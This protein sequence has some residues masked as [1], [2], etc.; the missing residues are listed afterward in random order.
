MHHVNACVPRPQDNA[1]RLKLIG[2]IVMHQQVPA[3]ILDVYRSEDAVLAEI[4]RCAMRWRTRLIIAVGKYLQP[5]GQIDPIWGHLNSGF[6]RG[7][8]SLATLN[9]PKIQPIHGAAPFRFGLAS[10]LARCLTKSCSFRCA[11]ASHLPP[12]TERGALPTHSGARPLRNPCL[13]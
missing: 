9:A 6:G 8:H 4:A 1:M 5:G 13:L 10:R 7:S 2:K 3:D 11:P 12:C